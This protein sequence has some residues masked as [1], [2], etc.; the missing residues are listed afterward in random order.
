MAEHLDEIDLKILGYLLYNARSN[1]SEIAQAIGISKNAVWSRYEKMRKDKVI[2]GATVNINYKTLGYECVASILCDVDFS[3]VDEVC[4][5]LAQIPDVFGPFLSLSR[6]NV[7]AVVTLKRMIDFSRI[8]EALQRREGIREIGTA[9]WTDVW[10]TPENLSM[11]PVQPVKARI[12]KINPLP[13]SSTDV[14]ACRVDIDEKDSLIIEELI[15]NSRISFRK[16][17]KRIG[18]S[19]DTVRRRYEQLKQNSV[20][21]ARIQIDAAKVGYEAT[22]YFSLRVE[23]E[24]SALDIARKIA[25]MPDVFYV[26]N[27]VGSYD[28]VVMLMMKSVQHMLTTGGNIVRIPGIRRTETVINGLPPKWPGARTYTSTMK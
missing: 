12:G 5:A 28:I 9:L 15:K 19:T 8:K 21:T 13:A 2:T 3:R 20:I 18:V 16:L 4:K 14:G 24:C 17:S 1:F 11:V 23:P 22:A 7:I 26:M 25:E 6:F 10:F 27:C